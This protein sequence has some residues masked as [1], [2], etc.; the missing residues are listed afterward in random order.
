MKQPD[1]WF[2]TLGTAGTLTLAT[3]NVFLGCV[4]GL[5]TISVMA[6]RLRREWR[7]RKD[8]PEKCP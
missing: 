6:L 7:A 5:L 3:V 2:G 8:P 1:L 4:A